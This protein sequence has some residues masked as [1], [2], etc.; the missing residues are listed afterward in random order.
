MLQLLLECVIDEE[1]DYQEIL[2][3]V[4]DFVNLAAAVIEEE[5]AFD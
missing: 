4:V 5:E 1:E 2:P 3:R